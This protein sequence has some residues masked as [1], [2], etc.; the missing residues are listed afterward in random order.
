MFVP[1]L[2]RDIG[3]LWGYEKE[4]ENISMNDKDEVL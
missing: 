4:E 3:D 2:D 1:S